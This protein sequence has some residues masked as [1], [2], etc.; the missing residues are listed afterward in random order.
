MKFSVLTC[1]GD[2]N[3]VV[4]HRLNILQEHFKQYVLSN[5]HFNKLDNFLQ[6]TSS[7]VS[8]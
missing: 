7:S 5:S 8:T 3:E 6:T 1:L 2:E 4:F